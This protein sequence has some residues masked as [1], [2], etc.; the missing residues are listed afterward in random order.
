MDCDFLIIGAGMAGASAAYELTG[1]EGAAGASV[2]VL[3]REEFPGYHTTGRSAAVYTASY[4]HPVIRALSAASR[5]FFDAPPAG[6]QVLDYPHP[7]L[8]GKEV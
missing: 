8:N 7:E 4:G 1:P 5:P 6:F 2:V 3:E